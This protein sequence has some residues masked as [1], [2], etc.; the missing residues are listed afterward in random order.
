MQLITHYFQSYPLPTTPYLPTTHYFH[1]S[2]I[3]V[4]EAD[5]H[6]V[7]VELSA[8][9]STKAEPYIRAATGRLIASL[10]KEVTSRDAYIT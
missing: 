1:C 3:P 2:L 9:L 10:F 7:A 8:K 5:I 6:I 4:D